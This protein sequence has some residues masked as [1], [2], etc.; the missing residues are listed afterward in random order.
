MN[1]ET[2]VKHKFLADSK[3]IVA[4]G[5]AQRPM[6]AP[7]HLWVTLTAMATWKSASTRILVTPPSRPHRIRPRSG[8]VRRARSPVA[9]RADSPATLGTLARSNP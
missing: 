5:L 4:C 6:P 8:H 2:N 9:R 3:A 7:S 1:D